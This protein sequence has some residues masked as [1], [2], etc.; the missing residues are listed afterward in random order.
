M[1]KIL[2]TITILLSTSL[3]GQIDL[4]DSTVQVVA[5][6]ETGEKQTYDISFT[7]YTLQ[8]IEGDSYYDT[9]ITDIIKHEVDITIM[10]STESSYTIE[11]L[12]KN[13]E[14]ESQNDMTEKIMSLPEGMSILIKTNE[15]GGIKE[16]INWEKMR[17]HIQNATET[18]KDTP[19]SEQIIAV[20]MSLYSSKE[21]IEANS[22]K[23]ILQ[24]YTF[25][26]GKYIL[27]EVLTGQSQV[28]N[29]YGD[30]PFDSDLSV[31]LYDIDGEN[32]TSMMTMYETVD[33]DQLTDATFNY[34][35]EW[36]LIGD[37]VTREEFPAMTNEISTASSIHGE[38]GWIIY[39]REEK[40][41]SAEGIINVEERLIQLKKDF[42]ADPVL[43]PSINYLLSSN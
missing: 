20:V 28:S 41:V 34:L 25:H 31:N 35:K 4:S 6:W 10:E 12:Y 21:L 36:E 17:D 1:K 16:V 2:I 29:S 24:F 19:D 42:V 40:Q 32:D 38:S 14:V 8:E 13:F 30:I 9:T 5:Y 3:Y 26:G 27:G 11:W 43:F 18:L 33:S 39:S 37:E 15:L 22:I 7:K 23:D